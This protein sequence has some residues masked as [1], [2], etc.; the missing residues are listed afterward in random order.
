MGGPELKPTRQ[1]VA[2][3]RSAAVIGRFSQTARF[4][5]MRMRAYIV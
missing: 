3:G 4:S 2:G 1:R 5:A